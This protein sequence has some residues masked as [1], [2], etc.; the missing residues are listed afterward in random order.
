MKLREAYIET[1]SER[2]ERETREAIAKIMI[3]PWVQSPEYEPKYLTIMDNYRL[4]W[5]N[6]QELKK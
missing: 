1:E 2:L 6:L 5:L 3:N 4:R